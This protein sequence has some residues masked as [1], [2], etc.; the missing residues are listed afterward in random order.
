MNTKQIRQTI[1]DLAIRGELVHQDPT[2]EPASVLLERI[3]AEKE[4]LIKDK[5]L[6]RDKKDNEPID[7]IPFELPEGW[8]WCRLG[9]VCFFKG[10][11][12]FKSNKYIE[13]SNNQVIRI[14]NVK[15]NN[16]ILSNQPVY[17]PDTLQKEIED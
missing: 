7:E 14:G 1:L 13:K 3:R 10:G 12:A 6:K 9:E 5:K 17:I 4:Q 11:Y 2:D 15:N 8:E 16:L